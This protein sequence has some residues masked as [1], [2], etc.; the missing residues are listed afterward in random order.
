MTIYTLDTETQGLNTHNFLM[1]VLLP[2]KG[3]ARTFRT[4][5]ELWA[6]IRHILETH[7][8]AK[9]TA[10]FYAHNAQ[11]DWLALKPAHCP[12]AVTYSNNPF[13]LDF[14]IEG[15]PA[16]KLIDTLGL[17]RGSLAAIGD[18]IGNPKHAT[19]EWLKQERY[20]PTREELD[21]AEHYMIQDAAVLRDYLL[22]LREKMHEY[23][24]GTRRIITAG[25]LGISHLLQRASDEP[26]ADGL[27]ADPRTH[28]LWPTTHS[29]RIR[30]AV[31]AG[32]VQVLTTGRIEHAD[33]LDLNSHYPDTLRRMRIPDLR[34]ETLWEGDEAEMLLVEHLP[35]LGVSHVE[36]TTA[37][38]PYGV[39]PIRLSEEETDYPRHRCTLKGTWTHAELSAAIARGYHIEKTWWTLTWQT[40]PTNPFSRPLNELLTRKETATGFERHFLKMLLNSSIGKFAQL[41]ERRQWQWKPIDDAPQLLADGWRAVDEH[42]RERLYERVLWTEE[43]RWHAPILNALVT[44]E[45]R[46]TLLRL[47][48]ELPPGSVHYTDTDGLIVTHGA[49]EEPLK[50]G[51]FKY[52][53]ISGELKQTHTDVPALIWSKK[54]YSIGEEIRLSGATKSSLEPRSFAAGKVTYKRM[55]THTGNDEEDGTFA[56]IE[57]DLTESLTSTLTAEQR[58]RE[59]TRIH[60]ARSR[61]WGPADSTL[62]TT[63]SAATEDTGIPAW[64]MPLKDSTQSPPPSLSSSS[65][66]SAGASSTAPSTRATPSSRRS[67]GRAGSSPSSSA[68]ASRPGSS[69]RAKKRATSPSRA[70][71]QATAPTSSSHSS[72]SSST[73]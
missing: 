26:N 52:S 54:S 39:L 3:K 64:S 41:R 44:A 29:D 8:R 61:W 59:R 34:T 43:P 9:R 13:I 45:A 1:G 72:T 55:R 65:P 25:Q 73:R 62:T 22:K 17:F 31:R 18:A 14:I 50:T 23:G 67:S 20:A 33:Y 46:L 58:L 42:G 28:T 60:D 30:E 53:T 10:Y 2:S 19:P 69:R 7:A 24:I 56:T 37:E 63:T 11:Y 21:E 68:R 57:R 15:R 70:A 66:T 71:S 40:L 16:G 5:E 12:E 4:K 35:Q 32:R 27:F 6:A 36:I 47:M 49:D 48:E 51:R 38:H